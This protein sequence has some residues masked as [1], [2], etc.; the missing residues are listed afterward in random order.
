LIDFES[1]LSLVEDS[2][3]VA[4][5]L[6]EHDGSI[7]C[8]IA[9]RSVYWLSLRPARHPQDRFLVRVAWDRYPQSPPSV[10]FAHAIGAGLTDTSAW[11]LITGYR[12]GSFDICQP[13]TKEAYEIHPEWRNGPESWPAEGGNPFLWVAQVLQN[14]F[15]TRYEGRSG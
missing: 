10:K 6:F 2:Q 4:E 15:D 8:E 1:Q 5:A 3:S 7:A 9:E 13:F 14:D 12:P 11:P